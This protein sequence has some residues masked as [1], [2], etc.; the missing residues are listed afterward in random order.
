MDYIGHHTFCRALQSAK[1][2]GGW[3]ME[4]DDLRAVLE[5]AFEVAACDEVTQTYN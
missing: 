3:T 5:E 1:S 2:D 4:M